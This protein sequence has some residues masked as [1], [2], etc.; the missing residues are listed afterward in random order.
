L[1][2][3]GIGK[4]QGLLAW[5]SETFD[6]SSTSERDRRL[7]GTEEP[8]MASIDELDIVIRRKGE[9][10]VASI[11]QLGLVATG[12]EPQVALSALE[13]KKRMLLE[14][15]QVAGV[16]DDFEIR[17]WARGAQVG[18]QPVRWGGILEFLVKFAIVL[19][20]LG[21]IGVASAS[22][23]AAKIKEQTR[24]G[25]AQ[26]WAKLE[27]DLARVADPAHDLSEQKKRKILSDIRTIVDHWKPFAAELA[28]FFLALRG[29]NSR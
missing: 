9:K 3:Q 29:E 22:V 25:G 27:S 15:M 23:V 10:I 24:M 18:G 2:S 7:T 19:V 20:V 1:S 6:P 16:A 28:P 13:Q 4:N 26:F 12:P 11:P 17:S 14:D 21:G 8:V 5:D